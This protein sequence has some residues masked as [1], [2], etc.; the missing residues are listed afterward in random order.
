MS[1]TPWT[2]NQIGPVASGTAY[3]AAPTSTTT[4][5]ETSKNPIDWF[6]IAVGAITGAAQG[7]LGQR[8]NTLPA[9]TQN[10]PPV[11]TEKKE[12]NVITIAV[13]I[14]GFLT[15]VVITVLIVKSVKK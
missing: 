11:D 12:S 1:V 3:G 14:F 4:M 9:Q 2:Y 10:V 8:Q 7:F 5:N 13:G 6:T 15:L